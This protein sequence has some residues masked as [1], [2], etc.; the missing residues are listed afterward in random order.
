M[1]WKES[2]PMGYKELRPGVVRITLEM[3]T[4]LFDRLEAFTKAQATAYSTP[5]LSH[6]CRQMLQEGLERAGFPEAKPH[7]KGKNGRKS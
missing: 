3:P 4:E 6:V 5:N 1:A 7:G 2:T